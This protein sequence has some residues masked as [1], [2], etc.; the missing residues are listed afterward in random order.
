MKTNIHF[1][2]Y[3]AQFFMDWEILQTKVVAKIKTHILCSTICFLQ[4]GA[5]YKI[6]W[7]DVVESSWN[8]MARGDARGGGGGEGETGKWGSSS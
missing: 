6:M 5:V 1:L 7:K 4:D 2:P 8:V 3:L